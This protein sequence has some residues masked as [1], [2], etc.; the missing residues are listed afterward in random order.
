MKNKNEK[1]PKVRYDISNNKLLRKKLK[2]KKKISF[3]F[4]KEVDILISII[5]LII[6]LLLILFIQFII[7]KPKI[8]KE[9]NNKTKIAL[10]TMGRN[11][12][13]YIKEFV[14]YYLNLGVDTLFIYDDNIEEKEKFINV[15]TPND[16]VVIEY[17]KPLGFSH[18]RQSFTHCYNKHKDEYDW[19]LMIDIDE[20][21]IIR[22]NTLRGY[23][24]DKIF[25]KCDTIKIHWL[26]ARDNDLLYYENKSLFERFKE[27]TFYPSDHIKTILKG[28]INNLEYYVHSPLKSPERNI[29]CD[30]KGTIL[31]YTKVNIQ[32]VRPHNTDRAYFIH[33]YFKSTEEY[34]R[35]FKRGYKN[36]VPLTL[37]GWIFNYFKNNKVT[38]EKIELFEKAFN[39]TLDKYRNKLK[40]K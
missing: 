12:I 17:T 1:R 8:L 33:F 37:D 5:K 9:K 10:C 4:F 14:N 31:N 21:L 16:S 36:W 27:E 32:S 6:I 7:I 28:G 38:I 2:N 20:Y 40:K 35:K 34:I 25:D 22:N 19:I 39:I 11:E 18:Q 23:L 29:S 26:M 15:I 30:N 24:N 3:E 13:L